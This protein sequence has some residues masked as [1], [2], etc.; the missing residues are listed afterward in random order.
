MKLRRL[1]RAETAEAG[2]ALGC[3]VKAEPRTPVT[4]LQRSRPGASSGPWW[5]KALV[6]LTSGKWVPS[7]NSVVTLDSK[8]L[9][10]QLLGF[11]FLFLFFD[12]FSLFGEPEI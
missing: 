1:V 2:R 12:V 4:A 11:L 10:A 6:T 9:V 3:P 8:S 7:S 5:Q